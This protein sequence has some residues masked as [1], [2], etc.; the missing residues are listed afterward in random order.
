MSS[1]NPLHP[2]TVSVLYH[3]VSTIGFRYGKVWYNDILFITYTM[4]FLITILLLITILF[5]ISKLFLI[6][7]LL[8][9]IQLLITIFLITILFH[10]SILFLIMI[11]FIFCY[12][13]N[14][15]SYYDT[16]PLFHTRSYNI[17][18]R[19]IDSLDIT[20]FFPILTLSW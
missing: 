1:R 4:P 19:Y 6:M 11:I 15:I 10:I 9:T 18:T 12:H 8:I 16:I 2:V 17:N 14:C 20:I 3:S 13:Y 7:I 5:L